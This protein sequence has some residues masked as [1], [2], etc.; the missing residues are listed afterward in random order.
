MTSKP[1]F[2]HTAYPSPIG[3][4]YLL[5]GSEGLLAVGLNVS[6]TDFKRLYKKIAPGEWL[7]DS[8]NSDEVLQAAVKSLDDFFR[9]GKPLH[10]DV[11]LVLEGT[12]F[13]MKVWHEL[14]KIPSGQTS[15]YGEIAGK[16]ASPGAARAVGSA[17]GA[18][19]I[20]LFVPCHRVVGADGRLCGFGGGGINVKR[21]L[22]AM[23]KER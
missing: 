3:T 2:R 15:T 8:A 5:S 11:P 17:C 1:A 14:M 23:E 18:N 16:I 12:D 13:Q 10:S 4:V 20:P 21:E 6:W 7:E 22:L 9:T 19:P